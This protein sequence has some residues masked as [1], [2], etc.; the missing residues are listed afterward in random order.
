MHSRDS[1]VI[2]LWAIVVRSSFC[3]RFNAENVRSLVHIHS[4]F[5]QINSQCNIDIGHVDKLLT[6]C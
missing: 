2:R 3:T 4:E 1:A 6:D 5:A